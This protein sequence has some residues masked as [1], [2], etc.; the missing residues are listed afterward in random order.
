M[1]LFVGMLV[2]AS[3]ERGDD[4]ATHGRCTHPLARSV[5]RACERFLVG[6]DQGWNGRRV[7][8]WVRV[9][10]RRLLSRGMASLSARAMRERFFV[11]AHAPCVCRT[12]TCEVRPIAQRDTPTTS[13]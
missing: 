9:L 1:A 6:A 8:G 2:A 3:G 10:H 13:R 11:P 12:I 7:G 5:I 4:F